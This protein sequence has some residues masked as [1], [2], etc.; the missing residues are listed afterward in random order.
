MESIDP[1]PVAPEGMSHSVWRALFLPRPRWRG[2]MHRM[3]IPLAGA[4]GVVLVLRGSTTADRVGA[5]VFVFGAV[6]MFVASGLVHLRRWSVP[7]YEA[8]FRLDHAAIFV[9][10]AASGTPVAVT[11]LEGT[12][13]RILFWALWA[14]ALLGVLVR[15]MPFHPPKGLMNSL[16]L[17]L[18]WVPVLVAPAL[19]TQLDLAVMLLIGVEGVLYT[20]GAFMLGAR[21]PDLAPGHFGYHEVWHTAVT[22]AVGVHFVVVWLILGA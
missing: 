12:S 8:L 20:T 2:T 6:F 21:W 15:V 4:A 1:A 18:G 22:A 10:I 5:A 16:F 19:V 9:F 7:V 17:G 3:A 13:G 14:G 11:G